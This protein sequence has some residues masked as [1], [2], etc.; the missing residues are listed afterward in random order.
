MV[1]PAFKDIT[2]PF[3]K[4]WDLFLKA[5]QERWL[6]ASTAF[7]NHVHFDVLV[8]TATTFLKLVQDKSEY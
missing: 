8:A 7:S 5:N 6:I 4:P 3:E 1:S 2:S